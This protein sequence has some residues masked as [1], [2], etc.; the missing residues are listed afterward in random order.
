ML[1]LARF[2]KKKCKKKFY[3]SVN[4]NLFGYLGFFV[5]NAA[6]GSTQSAGSA[7]RPNNTLLRM[8]LSM[9]VSGLQGSMCMDPPVLTTYT[10]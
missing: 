7:L 4:L 5:M 6:S 8:L 9:C 2:G 3:G 10:N 1:D